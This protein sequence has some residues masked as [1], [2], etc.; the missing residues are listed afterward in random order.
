MNGREQYESVR[1][2]ALGENK[3][4]IT[5]VGPTRTRGIVV[6]APHEDFT[7]FYDAFQEKLEGN[8]TLDTVILTAM[9]LTLFTN[10]TVQVL[11]VVSQGLGT[12]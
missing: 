11:G 7:Q 4:S 3:Y 6:T 2:T 10:P 12:T 9:N 1:Y 5:V 8:P